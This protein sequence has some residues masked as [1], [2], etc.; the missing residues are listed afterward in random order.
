[1]ENKIL[2]NDWKKIFGL[3]FHVCIT[4]EYIFINGVNV[5]EYNGKRI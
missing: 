1:M 2:Y 5:G 4:T 3:W